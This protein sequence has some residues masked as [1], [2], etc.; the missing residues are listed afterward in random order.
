MKKMNEKQ[1]R[2]ID[3]GYRI[4]VKRYGPLYHVRCSNG[5][6]IWTCLPLAY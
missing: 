4:I 2:E 6:W 1:M 3:G 5:R